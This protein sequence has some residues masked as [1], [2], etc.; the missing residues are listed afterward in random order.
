MEFYL[1]PVQDGS[2]EEKFIIYRPLLGLAFIG[3]RSMASL[4]QRLTAGEAPGGLSANQQDAAS[5]LDQIGY[6]K[7]D[8]APPG[9]PAFNVNTAVLMLTN[10][11]QLRCVY[12]YAAAGDVPERVLSYA[13]GAAA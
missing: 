6:L 7:P 4:A 13:S 2:T 9:P 11:C 5:F 3:N 12:C 1:I 10:R 8:P